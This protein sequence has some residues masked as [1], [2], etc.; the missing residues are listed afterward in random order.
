MFFLMIS[1]HLSIMYKLFIK[2]KHL[3]TKLYLKIC[4]TIGF[5]ITMTGLV[6]PYPVQSITS[7]AIWHLAQN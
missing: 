5:A 2:R 7:Q 4:V 6:I 1:K 3:T